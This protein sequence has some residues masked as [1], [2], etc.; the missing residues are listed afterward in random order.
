MDNT[1]QQALMK[2]FASVLRKRALADT[3]EK[4]TISTELTRFL[5]RK[6]LI[7]IIDEKYDGKVPKTIDLL[8]LENEE[9]VTHIGDELYVISYIT[10]QW[11]E[12]LKTIRDSD[13][14]ITTQEPKINTTPNKNITKNATSKTKKDENSGIRRSNLKRDGN[15][16]FRYS[17]KRCI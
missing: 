6:Q 4:E 8:F 10:K 14:S 16:F 12:G 15:A 7:A 9:L 1:Q 3:Q 17:S 13:T 2:H 11:S 5:S